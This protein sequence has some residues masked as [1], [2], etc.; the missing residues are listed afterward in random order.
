MRL[1]R[2]K[3]LPIGHALT[4]NHHLEV[5]V[6]CPSGRRP[7]VNSFTRPWARRAAQRQPSVVYLDVAQQQG[8]NPLGNLR[9]IASVK[10][11][12]PI[13]KPVILKA[14]RG[15]GAA[16][17]YIG[18]FSLIDLSGLAVLIACVIL[19]CILRLPKTG[20]AFNH[21]VGEGTNLPKAA[22]AT[23]WGISGKTLTGGRRK[24]RMDVR[25][26]TLA[27]AGNRM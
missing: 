26:A 1:A 12:L 27:K 2:Y 14:R 6:A 24:H 8:C 11:A 17:G 19:Q 25:Q 4:R 7:Q 16:R 3:I 10:G 9:E 21:I 20:W 18:Q 5:L 22:W 13:F 15:A 23:I